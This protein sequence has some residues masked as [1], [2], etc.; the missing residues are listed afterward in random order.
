M[1]VGRG[2]VPL[3]EPDVVVTPSYPVA[4][5]SV[6]IVAVA[7]VAIVVSAVVGVRRRRRRDVPP[8]QAAAVR[9]I[10]DLSRHSRRQRGQRARGTG[11]HFGRTPIKKYGDER[12]DQSGVD[13]PGD[14]GGG[15]GG[16][17]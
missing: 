8:S 4:M 7:V 12:H 16:G 10:R 1:T 6:S 3:A 9:A 17:D 11:P 14:S 5:W 15:G 2:Q 13:T